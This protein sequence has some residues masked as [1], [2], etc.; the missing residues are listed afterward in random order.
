VL[1]NLRVVAFPPLHTRTVEHE[2]EQVELQANDHTDLALLQLVGLQLEPDAI[3]PLAPADHVVEPLD[4]VVSFGY[5]RG[6]EMLE[7]TIAAM[8]ATRGEVSKIQ[9]TIQLH[10]PVYP[11][12]SGGPVFDLDGKVIGVTT[13]R[14]GEAIAVCIPARMVGQL[15][16]EQMAGVVRR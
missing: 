9:E 4:P 16:A 5:P 11:G 10:A 3:P 15:L 6:D 12:N 14:W 7:G 2:G 8:S 1:G 13:R